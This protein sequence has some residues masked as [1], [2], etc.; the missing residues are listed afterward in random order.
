M[1]V[2]SGGAACRSSSKVGAFIFIGVVLQVNR[3]FER[4]DTM[5]KEVGLLDDPISTKEFTKDHYVT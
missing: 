1:E 3:L 5:P 2:S 4:S